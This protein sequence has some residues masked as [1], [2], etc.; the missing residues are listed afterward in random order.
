MKP[1]EI[2][3]SATAETDKEDVDSS[4]AVARKAL[5]R[6]QFKFEQ[7]KMSMYPRISFV[8]PFRDRI[9]YANLCIRNLSAQSFGDFEIIVSEESEEPVFSGIPGVRHVHVS[10]DQPFNKA[11]AINAGVRASRASVVVIHDIDILVPTTYATI[12]DRVVRDTKCDACNVLRNVIYLSASTSK[13]VLTDGVLREP[14]AYRHRW[15]CWGGSVVVKRAAFNAVEGA[16]EQYVGYGWEDTDLIIKLHTNNGIVYKKMEEVDCF[17][18]N[19][20]HTYRDSEV[21]CA[22]REEQERTNRKLFDARWSGV[23]FS[24]PVVEE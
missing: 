20:E 8:L 1:S 14:V 21:Y 3:I 2:V 11:R 6:R 15:K 17:H 22:I 7:P 10:S 24:V 12:I 16:D 19:H 13:T 9:S 4:T 18:V 5:E 23:Q